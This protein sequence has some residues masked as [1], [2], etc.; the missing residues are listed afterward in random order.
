[1][2][3][4]FILFF[5]L[6][7]LL[8]NA[9]DTVVKGVG[10]TLIPVKAT[11]IQLKK[12]ILDIYIKKDT[13]QVSVYFEFYNPSEEVELTVGFVTPPV[14]EGE[15][16]ETG[17]FYE[18]AI[19]GFTVEINGTKEPYKK[20]ELG[21]SSFSKLKNKKK[22]FNAHD[23]IYY[24]TCRFRKGLNI[25]KHT[26]E[27]ECA[28]VNDGSF[29]FPY[30]LTTGKMWSNGEM[31]DFTLRISS[32]EYQYFEVPKSFNQKD[33]K[34]YWAINGK[35]RF[36]EADDILAVCIK[37]GK[38]EYHKSHFKP[39]NDLSLDV[40]HPLSEYGINCN[41]FHDMYQS[42]EY[43]FENMPPERLSI[44]RNTFYA[45]KGF[46]FKDPKLSGYF[47]KMIW[48]WPEQDKSVEEIFNSFTEEEK[49]QVLLI[50]K[51]ENRLKAQSG[52]GN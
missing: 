23:Y 7:P 29:E 10:S 33:K 1:M 5:L 28:Y 24:F 39:D 19:S 15:D 14:S 9:D 44:L 41:E 40:R 52:G 37:E 30:M 12:E 13:A 27:F 31:G 51:A 46:L 34:N 36:A 42:D 18:P 4:K 45:E 8:L 43:A 21:K 35:G 49:Q 22:G 48:Y 17:P 25:I 26:Y 2:K 3:N 20:Q 16:E 11:K 32:K 6:F 47:N 38:L 50:K